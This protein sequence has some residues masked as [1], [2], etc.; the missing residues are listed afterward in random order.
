M[1]YVPLEVVVCTP[2][3]TRCGRCHMC[4]AG[5]FGTS[6]TYWQLVAQRIDARYGA[7][8]HINWWFG[9]FMPELTEEEILSWDC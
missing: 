1:R 5:T 6:C 4:V 7:N 9:D 8:A 2:V 3:P